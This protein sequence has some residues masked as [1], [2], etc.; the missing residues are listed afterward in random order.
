MYLQ[1]ILIDNTP[2]FIYKKRTLL[3]CYDLRA[4]SS[5]SPYSISLKKKEK[6]AL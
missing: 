1:P 4:N 3:P 6:H 5:G 2:F